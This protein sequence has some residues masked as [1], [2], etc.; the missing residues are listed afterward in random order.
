M[1]KRTKALVQ[2]LKA[3]NEE[4]RRFTEGDTQYG[5]LILERGDSMFFQQNDAGFICDI[6]ARY[7]VIMPDSIVEWDNGNKISGEE[8]DKLLE[9]IKRLYKQTYLDDLELYSKKK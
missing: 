1:D 3:D 2:Q 5:M 9:V 8:K 6:S 4:V 7:A